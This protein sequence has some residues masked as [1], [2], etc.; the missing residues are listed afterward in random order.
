[1]LKKSCRKRCCHMLASAISARPRRLISWGES[2]RAHDCT[3]ESDTECATL[4]FQVHGPQAAAGCP[5][6]TRAGRQRSLRQQ[7]AGSRWAPVGV[8]VQRVPIP[9]KSFSTL[10]LRSQSCVSK[11]RAYLSLQQYLTRSEFS[12]WDTGKWFSLIY[13][14]LLNELEF[15]LLNTF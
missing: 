1:M 7:E 5:G 11:G 14:Y 3:G 10:G 15:D 13:L 12:G 2:C 8:P 9:C 4:S 6:Q